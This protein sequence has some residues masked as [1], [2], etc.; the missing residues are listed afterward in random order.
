MSRT[1]E[2]PMRFALIHTVDFGFTLWEIHEPE[3][4]DVTKSLH[5]GSF[6]A[7]VSAESPE[8][9]LKSELEEQGAKS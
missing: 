4:D 2:P 7:I 5:C 3:C 1:L 9:L 6:V 8:T